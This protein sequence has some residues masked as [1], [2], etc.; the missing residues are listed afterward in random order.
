MA[1]DAYSRP[2]SGVTQIL[3][4]VACVVPEVNDQHF[5]TNDAHDTRDAAESEKNA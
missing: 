4:R 1:C 3:R 2:D 5:Q